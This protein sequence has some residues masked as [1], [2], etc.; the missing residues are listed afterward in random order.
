MVTDEQISQLK[1]FFGSSVDFSKVKIKA[2]PF[3][4]G[5]RSWTCGNVIRVKRAEPGHTL[6]VDTADLIHE[7]GHVWQH[8]NAQLVFLSALWLNNQ[9]QELSESSIRITSAFRPE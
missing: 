4:S 5:N 6:T 9:G 2:S 8:Q 3:C 1:E 7:C